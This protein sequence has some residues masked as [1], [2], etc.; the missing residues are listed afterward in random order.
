MLCSRWFEWISTATTDLH[1]WII[2]RTQTDR[3]K[4]Y[5]AVHQVQAGYTITPLSQ[6]GK[7]PQPV[8]VT[9]DPTVDMKTPP[10]LQIVIRMKCRR[11]RE[12]TGV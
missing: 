7:A 1:L 2:G 10:M 8:A 9:I 4:D 3:P 11:A 6:L 12:R 5:D